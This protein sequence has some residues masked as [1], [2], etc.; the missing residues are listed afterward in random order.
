MVTLMSLDPS[1]AWSLLSGGPCDGRP[2]WAGASCWAVIAT[3]DSDRRNWSTHDIGV[4]DTPPV[5]TASEAHLY[6]RAPGFPGRSFSYTPDGLERV[7]HDGSP[8]WRVRL[9]DPGD[10]R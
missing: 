3:R 10:P 6:V 8:A 5:V 9:D 4:G 7:V 1:A 2:E